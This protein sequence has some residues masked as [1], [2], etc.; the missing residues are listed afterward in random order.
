MAT[1]QTA[2]TATIQLNQS[3]HPT[4]VR[5]SLPP[6][7]TEPELARLTEHIVQNI[8]RPHTGC[9]CMSGTISVLF[10]SAFQQAIDVSV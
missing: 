1:S 5:V 8:V 4:L 6:Q 7:I 2:R 10:E 9:T 3:A